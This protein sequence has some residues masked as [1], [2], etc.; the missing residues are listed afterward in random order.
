MTF[1]DAA[2]ATTVAA[3][4][5]RDG[6]RELGVLALVY[7]GYA[8]SRVLADDTL[9]PAVTRAVRI[10][11]VER[12]LRLDV[13]GGLNRWFVEHD[14]VG[15]AASFYY[16]GAHYVLTLLVVIWLFLRHRDA[17]APARLA[18]VG[19]TGVALVAYLTMPTA[20]PRLLGGWT[21]LL[22]LHSA[23]GWWGGEASAPQ[24]M[25]WLTNQ[26]A[27]FP[28]M[29]AGWALW[30]ALAVTHVVRRRAV[31]VFAWT[32]AVLTG[33]VVVGTGNHWVLD[34]VAGWAVVLIAWQAV[35]PPSVGNETGPTAA[36][37]ADPVPHAPARGTHSAPERTEGPIRFPRPRDSEDD[38]NADADRPARH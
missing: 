35:G 3:S 33:I 14:T 36:G 7:V 16:A 26:L 23:A 17:Y 30:V 21:D 32:H 22:A 4:P 9:S 5:R 27:A 2:P 6:L 34:V 8:A 20:P 12:L 25:G 15:V 1:L 18:L 31:V 38:A 28:S 24:G 29:H 19:A 11:D 13:E 10:L 37:A